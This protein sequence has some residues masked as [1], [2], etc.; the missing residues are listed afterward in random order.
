MDSDVAISVEG[1]SKRFRLRHRGTPLL[2]SVVMDAFKGRGRGQELWALRDVS[3]AVRK[4]RTLGIIG[5]NGR[6]RA[7]SGLAGRDG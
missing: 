1:V 4:G 2:K 7:R 3:F 6:G 5:A